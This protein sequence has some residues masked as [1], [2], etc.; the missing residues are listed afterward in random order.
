[1]CLNPD[2]ENSPF[3]T[4]RPYDSGGPFPRVGV[5]VPQKMT[6]VQDVS[7]RRSTFWIP[8]CA[9]MTKG[10]APGLPP[11]KNVIPAQAGIQKDPWRP[12]LTKRRLLVDLQHIN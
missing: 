4:N 5:G 7:R 10:D 2:I 11:R 3:L 9:G 12:N 8:A 1:M 6:S